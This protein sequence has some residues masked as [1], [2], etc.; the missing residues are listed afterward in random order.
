M[1]E[2]SIKEFAET[3]GTPVGR[4]LI[5]LNEAGLPYEAENQNINDADKEQL[6]SYLRQLHGKG[7][8]DETPS[9]RITLKRKTVSELKVPSSSTVGRKKT[10]T[11][12][13]RKR[14]TYVTKTTGATTEVIPQAPGA[15]RSPVTS[16][17]RH[18]TSL[19]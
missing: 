1:P 3:V 12:E 9:K 15:T 14:R 19:C 16:L 11:V 4:L 17:S 7:A 6:L 13:V 10:V 18:P 2:V 5:Q 8:E